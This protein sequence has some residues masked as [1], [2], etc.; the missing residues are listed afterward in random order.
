MDY[1]IKIND[2]IN[3]VTDLQIGAFINPRGTIAPNKISVDNLSYATET[4]EPEAG[5][6]NTSGKFSFAKLNYG[7]TA[8]GPLNIDIAA[9]HLNAGSLN[10]LKARWQ[11]IAT[12]KQLSPEEQQ[13]HILAA[14]RNEGAA[15]FTDNPQLEI[16]TFSF[17]TPTGHVNASGKLNF[18]GLTAADLN[19]IKPMLAKMQAELNLDVSQNIIED[20]AIAQTRGLFAME[21]PNS[22]QEQKEVDDTIR[23]LTSESLKTMIQDGYIASE[24]GAIKTQLI[25]ADNKIKLN[26][27]PFQL[28]ANEDVFAGLESDASAPAQ[29]DSASAPAASAASAPQE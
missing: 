2:L 19:D 12:E 20:F 17:T 23:L 10:A 4:S 25:V 5:Y 11:Q 27:K 22:V 18:N 8:Y 21:N 1:N 6:I 28:Q 14:V 15:L 7:D 29:A 9:N 13:K 24:N 26:G 3:T 16:R